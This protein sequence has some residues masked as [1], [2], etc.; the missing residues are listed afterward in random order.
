MDKCQVTKTTQRGSTSAP[1]VVP[2]EVKLCLHICFDSFLARRY[3][4]EIFLSLP[5]TLTT[6]VHALHRGGQWIDWRTGVC[7]F[8]FWIGTQKFKFCIKVL[9]QIHFTRFYVCHFSKGNW[10]EPLVLYLMKNFWAIL[11]FSQKK[12]KKFSNLSAWVK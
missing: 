11:S 8:G 6:H 1:L 12:G 3:L 2:V 10:R 9:P 5:V 7:H 4:L